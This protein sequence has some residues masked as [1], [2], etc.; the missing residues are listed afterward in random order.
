MTNEKLIQLSIDH[1]VRMRDGKRIPTKDLRSERGTLEYTGTHDCALCRMYWEGDCIDC[2]VMNKTG[3]ARC[4]GAPFQE[5]T[6]KELSRRSKKM[7]KICNEM[8]DFLEG[9]K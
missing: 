6:S 1:W 9:L 5:F 3:K 8:I 2:P 4:W 7:Q